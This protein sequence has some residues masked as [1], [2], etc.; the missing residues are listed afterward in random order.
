MTDVLTM[1]QLVNQA[2]ALGRKFEPQDVTLERK[3][4]A[5]TYLMGYNG[6]RQTRDVARGFT[7]LADF[8]TRL[9]GGRVLSDGQIKAVLNCMVA[10]GRRSQAQVGTPSANGR[11]ATRIVDLDGGDLPR[12]YY[13]VVREDGTHI[14][15][16]I[17]PYGPKAHPGSLYVKYLFGSDNTS[18][19]RYAGTLAPDGT[20]FGKG[21]NGRVA[22]ALTVVLGDPKTAGM[23]YALE[24]GNCYVCG[25]LL[26]DP[27]SIEL[28]IGPICRGDK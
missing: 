26:T 19:Y 18:D 16:R 24:S 28:G 2:D 4:A 10:E 1:D 6:D 8:R 20:W 5:V 12:G 13:T 11:G 22:E 14:T 15:L 9:I 21:G 7:L 3:A 17:G 25:R 27:T 23:A